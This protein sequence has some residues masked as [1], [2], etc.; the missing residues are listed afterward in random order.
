MLYELVWGWQFHGIALTFFVLSVIILWHE[1]LLIC[2]NS[3]SEDRVEGAVC[4]RTV[5]VLFFGL[6]VGEA[7]S[8][9]LKGGSSYIVEGT[10]INEA[11]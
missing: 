10:A 2:W 5:S 11:V 3:L 8:Q 1:F 6:E 9:N 4:M 7:R